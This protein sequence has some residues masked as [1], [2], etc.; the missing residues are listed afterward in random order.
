MHRGHCLTGT[1]CATT[2]TTGNETM[3]NNRWAV[4][5]ARLLRFSC[6]FCWPQIVVY[7]RLV[8]RDPEVWQTYPRLFR[9]RMNWCFERAWGLGK[10]IAARSWSLS[11]LEGPRPFLFP[12]RHRSW[13]GREQSWMTKPLINLIAHPHPHPHRTWCVWSLTHSYYTS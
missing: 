7:L 10:S 4:W 1:G 6:L 11:G 12:H 9:A 8:A 2:C 13:R 5:L 3:Y